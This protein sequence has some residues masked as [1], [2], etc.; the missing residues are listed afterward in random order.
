M[1]NSI[2]PDQLASDQ[3]YAICK[4]RAYP[5]SA[6]QGLRVD[7]IMITSS[8]PVKAFFAQNTQNKVELKFYS[9]VNNVKVI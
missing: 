9:P 1:T 3:I 7:W 5:G 4:G 6:G 8:L 2:E